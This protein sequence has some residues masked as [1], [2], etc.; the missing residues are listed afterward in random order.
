MPVLGVPL[1]VQLYLSTEVFATMTLIG[2]LAGLV[3]LAVGGRTARQRLRR[4]L[5]LVAGA[6][7]VALALGS[8]LL[9]VA[10]T[11]PVPY[12][13]VLFGGLPHGAQGA[14]D[15]LAYVIPGRFTVLGGHFGHRWGVDGN[16]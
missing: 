13:P 8:P 1:A 11:R 7:G 2:A 4:V 16:P 6:Y 5:G 10:F 12:K 9:Y 15:F 3:G 14:A